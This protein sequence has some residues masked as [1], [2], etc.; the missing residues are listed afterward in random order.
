[1][2]DTAGRAPL[3]AVVGASVVVA[4]A[5]FAT[6]LTR[7]GAGRLPESDVPTVLMVCVGLGAVVWVAAGQQPRNRLLWVLA[8]FIAS[9]AWFG[10]STTARTILAPEVP[11]RLTVDAVVPADLPRSAAWLEF[12]TLPISSL[13]SSL[14]LTFGLLLF[15]DGRLPSPRWRWVSIGAAV[16][17]AV[18][19]ARSLFV[20]HPDSTD[21]ISEHPLFHLLGPIDLILPLV[22]LSAVI[23]RFRHSGADDRTRFKWVVWGLALFVPM[24]L[25]GWM[26][27]LTLVT[28][29]ANL[30]LIATLGIAI[31]R[32]HLFDVDLVISRTFVFATLAV[33]IGA[34]Y[35]GVVV[36]IGSLL[37]SGEEPNAVLSV[38]ATALVAVG[39]QPLRR[40]LE[41]VANRLV[42]GRK[43]TPYEV[44]S[45]FSRRVAA[46]SDD[47]LDDA[48]RS[49]AEGTRADRVAISV[50][51]DGEPIEAAAWPREA[52]GPSTGPVSFPITDRDIALGSLD[53]FLQAGQQLQDD[54][55]RLAEQLASGMGLALRNQLLTER[56]EA[57]VEEL[58]ESR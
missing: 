14:L 55:R 30:V 22:A 7:H 58:R 4:A 28:V 19:F 52:V 41:R 15:P 5:S 18:G 37:G 38:G 29:L 26:S 49:L 40:R 23:V 33:F 34:V 2:T 9:T 54:D 31:T 45:E 16:V 32:H 10:A 47:L 25:F 50:I 13:A 44:L 56:L 3:R 24:T 53:V 27:G 6:M 42:F 48:A 46:T 1:M 11:F 21:V 12:I 57:R 17:L 36:G 39:F 8:A 43:A 51:I 35:V 20:W